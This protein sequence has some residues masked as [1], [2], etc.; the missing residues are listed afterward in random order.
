[1][2]EQFH[3]IYALPIQPERLPTRDW[4]Y[5][6]VVGADERGTGQLSAAEP[7]ESRIGGIID[8]SEAYRKAV[9]KTVHT[10]QYDYPMYALCHPYGYNHGIQKRQFLGRPFT[11]FESKIY[12]VMHDALSQDDRFIRIVSYKTSNP[13]PK[14]AQA[15]FLIQSTAG[16]IQFGFEVPLAS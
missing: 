7:G 13:E 8:G 5:I 11:W 14:T 6:H 9:W 3:D 12:Q 15:E 4:G 10:E 16:T 2:F 1:M